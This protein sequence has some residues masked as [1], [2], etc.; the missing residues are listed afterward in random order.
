MQDFQQIIKTYH[1]ILY[2][3]GRVYSKPEDFN[4]LYQEMLIAVWKGLK[5]FQGKSKMSTWLYR[6]AL[7]TALSYQKG[8]KRKPISG[9]DVSSLAIAVTEGAREEKEALEK[10]INRLMESIQKL[11][12]EDRSIVVLYLEDKSYDEIAEIIGISKSYVGVKINRIKKK[13]NELLSED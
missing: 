7:N 1:P 8:K 5:N 4:D 6:V 12:E 10:N 11:R 13:L 3:I 2:K 9:V